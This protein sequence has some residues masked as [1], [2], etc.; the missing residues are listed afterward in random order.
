MA[1]YAAYHRHP[2]NRLTHCLGVP[3]IMFALL[4][5]LS[6]IG[7]HAA[8]MTVTSAMV[9]VLILLVY[10]FLFD[11]S[12]AVA[13]TVVAGLILTVAHWVAVSQSLSVGWTVF[14]VCFTGG[15]ILQIAGH[16]LEGR[17][18]ALVD[19]LWQV[20]VAPVFLMAELFFALGFKQEMRD[21]IRKTSSAVTGH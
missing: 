2:L 17:R 13:M 6:W 11:V 21:R 3:L 20:F 18:P 12:L 8:G 1:V 5:P 9:L 4:V 14:G 15:W 19:N 7:V 10:Y 16:V